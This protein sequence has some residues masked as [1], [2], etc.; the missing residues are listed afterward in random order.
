MVT[1]IID[2]SGDG[3]GNVLMTPGATAVDHL[4]NAF[5]AGG[6]SDNVFKITP[7]GA[8]T[9]ILDAAGDGAGNTFNSPWDLTV[10]SSGNVFVTAAGTTNAFKI[11]P[12]GEITEIIDSTG[13]GMGNPFSF[14]RA[15][16]V[17]GAGSVYITAGTGT[18]DPKVFKV[19][20][21][22]MISVIIDSSGDG[23][24]NPLYNPI[25]IAADS[26]GNAYVLS[27][28]DARN[29]ISGVFKIDSSG[30][31][32]VVTK[33]LEDPAWNV[34][35]PQAIA[36][37]ESGSVYVSTTGDPLVF[38]ISP[39][40]AVTPIATSDTVG[41]AASCLAIAVDGFE[42]VY[43]RC[44]TG[45]H[46]VQLFKITPLGSISEI[47]PEAVI[48]TTE[49]GLY[50]YFSVAANT[51]GIVCAT[52]GDAN[53]AYRMTPGIAVPA[54]SK[55]GLAVLSALIVIAGWYLGSSSRSIGGA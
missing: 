44:P 3:A 34:Q 7:S 51:Q 14:P 8:I 22:G 39:A 19:T 54:L 26:L 33:F 12:Q 42:N 35:R 27:S 53:T 41:A 31:I 1:Q 24:G 20:P 30:A 36:V 2:D 55:V 29:P 5:V 25:G 37:A 15:I 40:G 45:A 48:A 23:M 4:G 10:D 32:E 47:M 28:G 6:G 18:S 17:D 52:N 11:G 46:K 49:I 43:V 16:A 50:Q 13:D 9:E 21:A 38:R